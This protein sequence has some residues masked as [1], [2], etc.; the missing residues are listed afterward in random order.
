MIKFW[1][2]ELK[3][4]IIL[5][6][7]IFLIIFPVIP[8]WFNSEF[9]TFWIPIIGIFVGHQF[10]ST[11]FLIY[12]FAASIA[13]GGVLCGLIKKNVKWA[14]LGALFAIIGSSLLTF[15]HFYNKIDL[16]NIEATID[17]ALHIELFFR[18]FE[19]FNDFLLILVGIKISMAFNLLQGNI[20]LLEYATEF[21]F[22][23]IPIIIGIVVEFL[24][25]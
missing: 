9:N 25:D 20:L 2:N 4:T 7:G 6:C 16:S 18:N 14:K 19:Q 12:I 23:F 17:T 15:F 24:I 22:G 3:N 10:V 13:F 5:G 1:D 21:Y 8:C 11:N